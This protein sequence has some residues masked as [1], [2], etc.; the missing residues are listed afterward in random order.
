MTAGEDID[1]A[2][3]CAPGVHSVRL[4]RRVLEP[5]GNLHGHAGPRHRTGTGTDTSG[6]L[7]GKKLSKHT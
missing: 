5:G 6:I 7:V 3:P 4:G 2:S 1:P